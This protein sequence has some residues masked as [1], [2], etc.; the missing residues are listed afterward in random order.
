MLNILNDAQ[1]YLI[2]DNILK[3][4]RKIRHQSNWISTKALVGGLHGV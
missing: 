3:N 2:D 1:F 4:V